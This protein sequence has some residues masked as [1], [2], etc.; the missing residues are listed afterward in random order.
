MGPLQDFFHFSYNQLCNLCITDIMVKL[1]TQNT[2]ELSGKN[3][4]YIKPDSFNLVMLSKTEQS[5]AGVQL[6]KG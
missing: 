2:S 1:Q 6:C 5:S 3:F 4:V